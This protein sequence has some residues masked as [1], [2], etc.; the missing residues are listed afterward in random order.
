M[1]CP[2]CFGKTAVV[3]SRP[4]CDC[5]KRYR[6]CADCGYR[7]LTMEYEA[8]TLQKEED[9]TAMRANEYQELAQRT[10]NKRLLWDQKLLNGALGLCGESGE[11]ADLIKKSRMQGHSLDIEHIAKELG[12][13]CWYIAEAASAINYTLEDIMKMN[14]EKLKK[15]YPDGFSAERSMHREKGDI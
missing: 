12:D 14:I 13:V 4:E 3:D 1:D 8:E 7:F 5:V 2:N 11:I 10:S 9:R 15:R 6:R